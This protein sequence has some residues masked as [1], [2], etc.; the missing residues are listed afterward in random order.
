[1]S[2][3]GS[4]IDDIQDFPDAQLLKGSCSSQGVEEPRPSQPLT[5]LESLD[6]GPDDQLDSVDNAADLTPTISILLQ[7]PSRTAK[8]L[9]GSIGEGRIV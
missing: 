4:A 5:G 3:I 8:E 1:M 9:L 2:S 7:R 6:E